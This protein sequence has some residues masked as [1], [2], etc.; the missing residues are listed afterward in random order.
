MARPQLSEPCSQ[1]LMMMPD[2][3]RGRLDN[4]AG[5]RGKAQFIRRAIEAELQRAERE[6]IAR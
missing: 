4:I 5:S 6:A 2:S 3:L 1:F